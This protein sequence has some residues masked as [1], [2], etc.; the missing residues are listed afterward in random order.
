M[1]GKNEMVKTVVVAGMIVRP[2]SAISVAA[3][4]LLAVVVE[5]ER[6]PGRKID[7]FCV[8][9]CLMLSRKSVPGAASRPRFNLHDKICY[10]ANSGFDPGMDNE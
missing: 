8:T 1:R 3:I 2:M 7:G 5:Q 10:P 4:A 9:H 6:A